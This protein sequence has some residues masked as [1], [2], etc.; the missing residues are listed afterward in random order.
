MNKFT[1]FFAFVISIISVTAQVGIGTTNPEGFLDL[2][3]NTNGVLLPRVSLT[4]LTSELPIVNPQLGSIPVSTL[5]FHDGSNGIESGFYYWTSNGWRVLQS[6]ENNNWNLLGNSGTDSSVNFL[7]T[8][9]QQDL[10][11]KTT[12]FERARVTSA[13]NIGIGT[14]IPVS[15]LQVTG[16]SSGL[17]IVYAIQNSATSGSHAVKGEGVEGPTN[18]YLGVQGDNDFDT[19]TWNILGREV[20]VLG[21]SEGQTATDNVGVMGL[22]NGIGVMG[23]S[24]A[25]LGIYG[26]STSSHGIFSS[27]SAANVQGLYAY[28]YNTQGTG[29]LGVG[30]NTMGQYLTLGSGGAFTGTTA[31][32]VSLAKTDVTGNG[33]ITSGSNKGWWTLA[34]GSGVAATGFYGVYGRSEDANGAGIIGQNTSTGWT[35]DFQGPM[36]AGISTA[37]RHDFYGWWQSGSASDDHR[38]NPASGNWG[39]IGDSSYYWY[40]MYSNNYINVSRRE[41]KR[42]I[43]PIANNE[44]MEQV[45]MFDLDQIQ[46]SFYKYNCESDSFTSG[47]EAKFRPNKHLGVILDEAPDYLKD[48]TLSG[49]DIYAI[50]VMALAAAKYNRKKIQRVEKTISDFGVVTTSASSVFIPFHTEFRKEKSDHVPVITVTSLHPKSSLYIAEITDE[51]FRVVSENQSSLSLNWIAMAKVKTSISTSEAEINAYKLSNQLTVSNTSKELV[52]QWAASEKAQS[53]NDK[54]LRSPAKISKAI[55]Y[56]KSNVTTSALPKVSQTEQKK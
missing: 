31:G 43:Q 38:I 24:I 21:I 44:M 46:P 14:S 5:V 9:D 53:E 56:E 52:T 54:S 4:N 19:T 1:H 15:L 16:S 25:N 32:L 22:S 42:E 33:I 17:P 29:I 13:G 50:S 40:Y 49:I 2:T 18:G 55:P 37:D 12:N 27:T 36:R 20:G 28:N 34:N 23:G 51:G 39:Y 3:S 7:G 6:G 45:L 8:T 10:V 47:N 30:N 41:T 48:N 35:G 26:F 11:I